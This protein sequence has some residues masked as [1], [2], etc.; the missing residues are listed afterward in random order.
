MSAP[1]PRRS[2]PLLRRRFRYALPYR[3][4]LLFAVV[5]TI[6]LAAI[7]PLRP[8]LIQYSVDKCIATGWLQG[9]IRISVI[10]LGVLLLETGLRFWFL[11]RIN[12][13]GQTVV[14]DLRKSVFHKILFQDIAY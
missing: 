5:M 4:T 12:W 14:N 10:Q 3:R 8:L 13:L 6:V 2:F 7:T 9:L 11:Y 1:T